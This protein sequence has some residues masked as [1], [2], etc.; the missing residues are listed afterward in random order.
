M[1]KKPVN[2]LK[3]E[4][5]SRIRAKREALRLSRQVVSEG[6]GVALSTLQAWENDEREPTA[7][8]VLKLSIY[9]DTSVE[10]LLTGS[11]AGLLPTVISP[12]QGKGTAL[13]VQGN[14]VDLDEFVF[15]PRYDVAAAAG[16][17]AW[18]DDEAPMFTVSFRRYWVVNHLK[19][20]PSQLSVI[21]VRGDSMEGVLN[22]KDLILINHQD[23]DPREGIYVLRIDGQLLVKRVQRLPA[24]QLR[25]TSTNPA[26]EPFTI[27]LEN[28]PGDFDIVGK[29][30]WYGRVV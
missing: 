9:L 10:W 17:G 5:G 19:T 29:V 8:H 13:D 14:T 7:S 12:S 1:T 25:V 2:E 27:D 11:S 21:S 23:R 16:Y 4:I 15:V 6:I 26:Y 22:D 24:S 18:N 3:S 20:D 30:V 28:I